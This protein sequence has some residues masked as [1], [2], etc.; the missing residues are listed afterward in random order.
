MLEKETAVI[1]PGII[2]AHEMLFPRGGKRNVASL[3]AFYLA[4]TAAYLLLRLHIIPGLMR[5]L[6]PV[7]IPVVVATWPSMMLFYSKQLIWPATMSEHH[8]L[9]Y[10]TYLS[11]RR[12]VLPVLLL[13]AATIALARWLRKDRTAGFASALLV[14]PILPVLDLRAFAGG[15]FVH[16]RYLYLPSVGFCLLVVLAWKRLWPRVSVLHLVPLLAIVGLLSYRTIRE[17]G[18]WHDDL[19]LFQR[20]YEVAPQHPLA[21]QDLAAAL[22][23]RGRPA[24]ALPYYERAFSLGA[25]S[26]ELAYGM[27]RAYFDLED[28]DRA[29]GYFRQARQDNPNNSNYL[30]FV[31]L[32]DLRLGHLQDAEAEI[33]EAIRIRPS[34]AA[35]PGRYHLALAE[36][37]VRQGNLSGAL[38]EYV[39]ELEENPNSER[40][41][42]Q[43]RNLQRLLN[44]H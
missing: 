19:L 29:A 17:S 25:R 36:I 23:M 31:G 1:L 42:Q 40:A 15:E 22:M 32:S 2:L 16:D 9:P 41:Q 5:V 34:I 18:F 14:I 8:Y 38:A 13:S 27:G 35:D 43:S 20:A 30:L 33:R 11:V 24:D 21:S 26:P 10:V 44:Q 37:L 28:W 7:P 12:L 6:A 39:A 4:P 3:L